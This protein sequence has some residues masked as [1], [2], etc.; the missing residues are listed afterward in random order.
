MIWGVC[1]YG[2]LSCYS[3]YGPKWA[4]YKPNWWMLVT[5]LA[6][7]L[8]MPPLL[9]ASKSS[10]WQFTGFL[11][12]ALI[13]FVAVTPDYGRTTTAK[14]IHGISAPL[15]AVFSILYIIFVTPHLWWIMVAYL[16]ICG[17]CTLIFG[18]Y[19]WNFW[20]E[21]VAFLQTYTVV[22]LIL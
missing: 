9:A 2:L 17:I 15:S 3:A 8:I 21:L 16:V 20:L 19:S 1:K 13:L 4:E 12:P 10:D 18:K 14:L 7:F 5:Y 22:Y 6:A 11:C